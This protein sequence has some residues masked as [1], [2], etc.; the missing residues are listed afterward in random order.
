LINGERG[1]EGVLDRRDI[2]G[3]KNRVEWFGWGTHCRTG[4]PMEELEK[5]RIR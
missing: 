3:G 1:W 5:V 2:V 4:L